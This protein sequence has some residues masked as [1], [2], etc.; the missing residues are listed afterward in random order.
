MQ[1]L[2]V[3]PRGNLLPSYEGRVGPMGR[4]NTA[5]HC[6]LRT[7]DSGRKLSE[8]QGIGLPGELGYASPQ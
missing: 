7:W 6:G 5:K 4:R 3:V 2:Y 1:E 8:S